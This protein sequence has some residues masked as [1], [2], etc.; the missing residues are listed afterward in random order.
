MGK[1]MKCSNIAFFFCSIRYNYVHDGF[2][3]YI[4]ELSAHGSTADSFKYVLEIDQRDK[5]ISSNKL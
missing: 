2:S 4:K 5:H 1:T 3:A